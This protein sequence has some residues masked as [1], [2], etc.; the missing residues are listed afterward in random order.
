MTSQSR[1]AGP[2]VVKLTEYAHRM[3][4]YIHCTVQ[5]L[6]CITWHYRQRTATRIRDRGIEGPRR[7]LGGGG[8]SGPA[9]LQRSRAAGPTPTPLRGCAPRAGEQPRQSKPPGAAPS[10]EFPHER[11]AITVCSV[12][13]RSPPAVLHGRVS[14]QYTPILC[15]SRARAHSASSTGLSLLREIEWRCDCTLSVLPHDVLQ[16]L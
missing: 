12:G 2:C 11:Q 15:L 14:V 3:F 10:L 4:M 1:S 9:S 13:S 16:E 6:R 7:L 5:T 8:P